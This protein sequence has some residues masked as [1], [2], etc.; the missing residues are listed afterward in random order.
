MGHSG[1]ELVGG[2]I[3]YFTLLWPH[4]ATSLRA[5]CCCEQLAGSRPYLKP[6]FP[7]P[8]RQHHHRTLLSPWLP[9]NTL[10]VSGYAQGWRDGTCSRATLDNSGHH[11]TPPVTLDSSGHQGTPWS[12]CTTLVMAGHPPS[13]LAAAGHL[14][15][16]Q[17]AGG[18]VSGALSA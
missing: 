17:T 12:L 3:T 18:P 14:Q 15:T 9:R 2:K 7:P 13:S 8:P 10:I 1:L 4:F 11:G 5:C 6:I 16:R